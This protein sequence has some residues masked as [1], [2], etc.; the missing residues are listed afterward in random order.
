MKYHSYMGSIEMSELMYLSAMVQMCESLEKTTEDKKWLQRLRSCKTM[1]E[2]TAA[3]R[4]EYL[5]EKEQPKV[6]AGPIISLS[7]FIPRTT[8]ALTAAR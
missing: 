4:I 8:P 3:E 1:L 2:K 6:A 5:D 7:E